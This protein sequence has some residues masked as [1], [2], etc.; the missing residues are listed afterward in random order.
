MKTD[1][2]EIQDTEI[3]PGTSKE[4]SKEILSS[5]DD[6]N[7]YFYPEMSK[8]EMS[9]IVVTMPKVIKTHH[10]CIN[11]E[12]RGTVMC[13]LGLPAGKPKSRSDMASQGICPKRINFLCSFIVGLKSYNPDNRITY[14]QWQS[15]MLTMTTHSEQMK[16]YFL[17]GEIEEKIRIK[18][19][20]LIELNKKDAKYKDTDENKKKEKEIADLKKEFKTK[21]GEW[22]MLTDRLMKH[23]NDALDREMPKKIET[24]TDVRINVQHMNKYL[25]D[26]EDELKRLNDKNTDDE[27]SNSRKN[28]NMVI[29]G[30]FK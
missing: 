16:D 5:F 8:Q 25:Q 7:K 24:T 2:K 27:K 22:F 9:N 1:E 28:S 26:A 12:W 19:E 17:M 29:D 14:G 10:G 13:P 18:Q 11:C 3:I 23:N 30:E 15:A 21:K 6:V 4:L 20:E